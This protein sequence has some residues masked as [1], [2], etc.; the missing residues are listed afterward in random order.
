MQIASYHQDRVALQWYRWISK[1]KD[2]L[3]WVEL[4]KAVLH[5]FGPMDYNDPLEALTRLKQ[6]TTIE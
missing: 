3:T 2:P 5:R 4:T 1:F 6:V